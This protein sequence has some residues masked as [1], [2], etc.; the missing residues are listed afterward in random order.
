MT[1]LVFFVNSLRRSWWSS[2]DLAFSK[3]GDG[4]V[5]YHGACGFIRGGQYIIKAWCSPWTKSAAVGRR[6]EKLLTQAIENSWPPQHSTLTAQFW[7]MVSKSGR[8]AK[9]H[10]TTSVIAEIQLKC[11]VIM[12]LAMAPELLSLKWK[13]PEVLL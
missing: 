1:R 5:K 3:G 13:N 6:N 11:S 4:T 2:L 12:W 10:E 7:G 9:L 8:T